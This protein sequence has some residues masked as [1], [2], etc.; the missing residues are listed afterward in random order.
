MAMRKI[1]G[2]ISDEDHERVKRAYHSAQLVLAGILPPVTPHDLSEPER[3]F[4]QWE[5]ALD[6]LAKDVELTQELKEKYD[7]APED[8]VEF[9]LYDGTIVE[10]DD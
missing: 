8:A 2:Y 5:A 10:A 7:I 1:I 9:A 6:V 3:H 4:R